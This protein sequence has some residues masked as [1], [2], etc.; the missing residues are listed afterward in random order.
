MDFEAIKK[1]MDK[2][3]NKVD[4]LKKKLDEEPL[5]KREIHTLLIELL[6]DQGVVRTGVVK[7]PFRY[8]LVYDAI[9][10]GLE[11]IYFWL[12]DF[13]R[14]KYRGLDYEVSKTADEYEASVGSG[15]FGEMGT[16]ATKMQEQAMKMM[17][18]IN[19]V[20][21]SVINL[22]YDLK[23]FEIRLEFYDQS[24]SKIKEERE[25]AMLSLKQIW[26]DQVDIKKGRG[27]INMLAQQLQFVTL[28]DAFM[29][30]DSVKDAKAMDLNDRVKRILE[31]RIQEFLEWK[32]RS[33]KELRKRFQ[34]EKAYVRSQVGSLKLYASWTKPYLRAAQQL[35]MRDFN[36]PDIVNAFSNLQMELAMFGKK[37]IGEVGKKKYYAC[38]EIKLRYRTLPQVMRTQTGQHYLHS[39][40]A[41]VEI[42]PYCMT[43]E[44]L[45]YL[46]KQELLEG[47]DLIEDMVGV[48]LQELKEDLD[49]YLKGEE[50]EKKKPKKKSTS[51]FVALAGGFKD[52]S[53]PLRD[54]IG[55][56]YFRKKPESF[57]AKEMRKTAEDQAKTDCGVLYDVYKKAHG[58]VTW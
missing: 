52:I 31:A 5:L 50:E 18:T 30:I 35:G 11:P 45:E 3:V 29:M 19:A 10:E 21:R 41:D 9:G 20:V 43:N 28:R 14:D 56:D 44:D 38:V 6:K 32:E 49:K 7:H 17:T 40:R 27:S 8:R 46:S 37:K 23:E 16:R 34:I 4:Y 2:H 12:L 24:K 58:M 47:L 13:L 42:I 15:Y 25:A 51:P 53:G 33:E 57:Y 26:M 54:I 36:S 39:G 1:E 48:P 22:L 55:L